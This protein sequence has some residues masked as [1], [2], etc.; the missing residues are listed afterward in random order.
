MKKFWDLS[1]ACDLDEGLEGM[2]IKFANYIKLRDFINPSEGFQR[3]LID[4]NIE[5]YPT[6]YCSL[7]RNIK[8]YS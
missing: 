2:L 8:F 7:G 6:K 1:E 4:L 5:I 3:I